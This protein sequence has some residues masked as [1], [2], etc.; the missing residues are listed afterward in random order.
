M[1]RQDNVVEFKPDEHPG[2][3]WLPRLHTRVSPMISFTTST[4]TTFVRLFYITLASETQRNPE[5]FNIHKD[6]KFK[7]EI[8]WASSFYQILLNCRIVELCYLCVNKLV[9]D[10]G[11][12][13]WKITFR[14]VKLLMNYIFFLSWKYI[15]L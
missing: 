7:P 14:D 12:L 2:R 1:I 11:M 4:E 8:Y 3:T 6:L 13:I 15:Q 10:K 5:Q 9:P